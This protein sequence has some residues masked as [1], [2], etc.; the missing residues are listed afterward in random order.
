MPD[1]FI[2]SDNNIIMSQGGGNCFPMTGTT[3]TWTATG[4]AP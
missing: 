1:N 3:G 2:L 4:Y